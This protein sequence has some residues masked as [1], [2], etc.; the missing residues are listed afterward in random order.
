MVWPHRFAAATLLVIFLA[1]GSSPDT[2]ATPAEQ[3]KQKEFQDEVYCRADAPEQVKRGLKHPLDARFDPGMLNSASVQR[4]GDKITVAGTVVAKNDF[5]GELTHQYT[6]TYRVREGDPQPLLAT[7][8][9]EVAWVNSRAANE[10]A[11]QGQREIEAQ[12]QAAETEKAK[13][14]ARLEAAEREA[15]FRTWTDATGQFSVEARYVKRAMDT[16]TLERRDGTTID[17]PF[18]KLSTTDQSFV[19]SQ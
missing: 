3:A 10:I 4:S 17:V 13:E 14:H 2:P 5:G 12:Q 18:A 1:C 19:R 9:G 8:D 11:T 16:V 7:L 6:V 15:S